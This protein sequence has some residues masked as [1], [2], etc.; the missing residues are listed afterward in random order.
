MTNKNKW[1]VAG[2]RYLPGPLVVAI[3][4]L[5]PDSFYDGSRFKDATQAIEY[6]TTLAKSGVQVLDLGAESTRPG[7]KSPDPGAEM[8]RLKDTLYGAVK[9]KQLHPKL[10]VSIDTY[11]SCTA[12]KALEAGVDIINDVSA[13]D[14]D[15]R[16][17]EILFDYKPGYVLMHHQGHPE[18]MQTAPAYKNVV[19]EVKSFLAAKIDELLKGGFPEENIIL[20]PGIGFGKTVEHNLALLQNL[21]DFKELGRPLFIGISNKSLFGDMLG[22]KLNERECA[23][24][25]A[26]TL[27]AKQNIYAHRVHQALDTLNSLKI[28]EALRPTQ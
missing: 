7:S 19:A 1:R 9:L 8:D 12:Q 22:L 5:T 13:F 27:L 4:N 26:V 20:D 23:T 18:T 24:Q 21:E 14:F 6:C 17:K 25:V 3:I 15:P 28:V 11:N 10:A 2:G 16:L